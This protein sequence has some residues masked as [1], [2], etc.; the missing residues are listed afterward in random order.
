MNIGSLC[1]YYCNVVCIFLTK[2][3]FS[4]PTMDNNLHEQIYWCVYYNVNV[5]FNIVRC[6]VPLIRVLHF[7]QFVYLNFTVNRN[8]FENYCVGGDEDEL[9]F[10]R[11]QNEGVKVWMIWLKML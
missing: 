5:T 8:V 1:T 6:R 10:I 7:K 2:D 9:Q 3:F 4:I 11:T